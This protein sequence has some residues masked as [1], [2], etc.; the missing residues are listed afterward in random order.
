MMQVKSRSKNIPKVVSA[1][2]LLLVFGMFST[3]FADAPTSN[4][5]WPTKTVAVGE[6]NNYYNDG[7]AK[8]HV[9]HQGLAYPG[10]YQYV[11]YQNGHGLW[12]GASNFNDGSKTWPFRASHVGYRTPG[13]DE[14]YPQSSKITSKLEP[15]PQVFVDGLQSFKYPVAYDSFATD[16]PADVLVEQTINTLIGLTVHRKVWA[17][18]NEYHDNYHIIELVFENTGI[19]GEPDDNIEIPEQTLEGIHIGMVRNY[20]MAGEAGNNL[21]GYGANWGRNTM[22]DVIGDDLSDWY[23]EQY[24]DLR[25]QYAWLGYEPTQDRL[26][27]IGVPMTFES[28]LYKQMPGDTTGRMHS[29]NFAGFVTLHADNPQDAA[30]DVPLDQRADDSSQ[31]SMTGHISNGGQ[32]ASNSADDET[33]LVA[34]LELLTSGHAS[35]ADL[36]VGEAAT[37]PEP[38]EDWMQRMAGQSSDPGTDIEG[39]L[40]M[41][42]YGPYELD[43]GEQFRIVQ[44]IG[45]DGLDEEAALVIGEQYK[46]LLNQGNGDA[47]IEFDSD[48]NGTIEPDEQRSKNMWVMTARDSLIDTWFNAKANYES[49]F[50]IPSPPKPPR[51]F[52]VTSKPDE[53]ELTWELYDGENPQSFE[54][55]RTRSYVNAFRGSEY[56]LIATPD[57][58]ATNYVDSDVS[59]GVSYFYYMKVVGDV[60]T[61]NTG[62]T[63]TGVPL[64]SNRQFTQTYNPAIL[65]RPPGAQIDDVKIVPNPYNLNADQEIR[66]PDIQDKVGFLEIPGQCDIKIYTE[67]GQLVRSIEHRDLSGDEYW[68]LTTDANQVV[69]S[70]IYIVV[71]EDIETGSKVIKKMVIIR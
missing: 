34:E 13:A 69:S 18:T 37:E 30:D 48:R 40:S 9:Y 11:D 20:A 47:D 53:I 21:V 28:G 16:M 33:K 43:P 4:W 66:W 5:L 42:G 67:S 54:I 8:F 14:M 31:P 50:S 15:Q 10:W 70:G 58:S 60:N 62:N 63:P 6:L 1:F 19:A 45:I 65:K 23:E 22:N 26:N 29:A 39:R 51:N 71:V 17:F 3:L 59:R 36:V 68:N 35:H 27:T 57:G 52:T 41:T 55:Y 25:T 64:K 61:D 38:R 12:I 56:E 49:G 44:A 32:F 46:Q 2:A 24:P 7:G